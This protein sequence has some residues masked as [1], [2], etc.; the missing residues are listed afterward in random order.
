V[1]YTEGYGC[2]GSNGFYSDDDIISSRSGFN[3][4]NAWLDVLRG[5]GLRGGSDTGLISE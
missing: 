4:V 2:A 5:G 1:S 3:E